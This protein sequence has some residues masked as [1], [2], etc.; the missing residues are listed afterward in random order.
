MKKSLLFLLVI[1]KESVSGK[2]GGVRSERC[3]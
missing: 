1:A 3:G 2:N